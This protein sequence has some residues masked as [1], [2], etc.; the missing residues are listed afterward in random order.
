MRTDRTRIL[1]RILI[2]VLASGV[3]LS[4]FLTPA[5]AEIAFEPS[6]VVTGLAKR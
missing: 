3:F 5:A 6:E 2:S 1:R 4:G